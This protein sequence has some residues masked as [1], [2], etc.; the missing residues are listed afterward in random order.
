MSYLCTC[1]EKGRIAPRERPFRSQRKAVSLTEKGRIAHSD[2]WWL[3][4][5]ARWKRLKWP[6]KNYVH[7]TTNI[8]STPQRTYVRKP[9]D[10]CSWK[11][12]EIVMCSG[13]FAT[14][15]K[16]ATKLLLIRGQLHDNYMLIQVS[17]VTQ[18]LFLTTNYTNFT[19]LLRPIIRFILWPV[20]KCGVASV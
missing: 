10:I 6:K 8:G 19:N 5:E 12:Y 2:V 13:T 9:R 1:E 11:A 4:E 15:C 16:H 7:L 20:V 14:C 18:I 17:E 3:M